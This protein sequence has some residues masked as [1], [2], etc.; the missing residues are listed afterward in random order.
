MSDPLIRRAHKTGIRSKQIPRSLG[1]Q[2]CL[3]LILSSYGNN[4]LLQ[5]HGSELLMQS[6][7]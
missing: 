1:M 7:S 5:V 6:Q 4:A 3:R 2:L